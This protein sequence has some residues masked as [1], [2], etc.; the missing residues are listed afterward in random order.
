MVPPNSSL[1]LPLLSHGRLPKDFA[2]VALWRN[3]QAQMAGHAGYGSGET[4]Q[5]NKP[6]AP[7]AQWSA[8]SDEPVQSLGFL[9]GSLSAMQSVSIDSGFLRR[10]R[11]LPPTLC[12]SGGGRRSFEIS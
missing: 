5:E 11:D 4:G 9:S 10:K 7:S 1:L 8:R 2:T 12:S 3:L 6:E